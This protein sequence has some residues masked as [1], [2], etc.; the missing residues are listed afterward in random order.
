MR[1]APAHLACVFTCPGH[2][3][4]Y[5]TRVYLVSS[6]LVSRCASLGTESDFELE[7]VGRPARSDCDQLW[8]RRAFRQLELKVQISSVSSRARRTS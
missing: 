4:G 1:R 7:L 5:P 6:H 8:A 2:P 3:G